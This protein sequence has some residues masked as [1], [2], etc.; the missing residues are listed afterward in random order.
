[1][2]FDDIQGI[3]RHFLTTAGGGLVTSGVLTGTQEQ[4]AVGSVMV[5]LGIA[6]S[7]YQKKQAAAKLAAA[8]ATPK[9]Q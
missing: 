3:I 2:N 4:D 9:G 1:M 6:W 5:L 7:I 8:T